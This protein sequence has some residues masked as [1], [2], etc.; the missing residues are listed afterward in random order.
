MLLDGR[1]GGS[2]F[3][4]MARPLP[5]D[6]PFKMRTV[7]RRSTLSGEA[8][9]WFDR[10]ERLRGCTLN[11]PAN[12]R[13]AFQHA[14]DSLWEAVDHY[15]TPGSPSPDPDRLERIYRSFFERWPETFG[16]EPPESTS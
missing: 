6:H 8:A 3:L 5:E 14:L 15:S 10:A 16:S 2:Y 9:R 12:E 1:V 11:I 7:S 4:C 13:T